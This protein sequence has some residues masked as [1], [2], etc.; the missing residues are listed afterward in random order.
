MQEL[1]FPLHLFRALVR[2][3]KRK[4]RSGLAPRRLVVF[5]GRCVSEIFLREL[6]SLRRRNQKV[7]YT[8][9]TRQKSMT[10]QV[11]AQK[12]GLVAAFKYRVAMVMT[13]GLALV[14]MASAEINFTPIEELLTAVIDL[15][16]SFMDLVVAIAPLVVV[17]AIVSFIL[18]FLDRIISMLNF[19]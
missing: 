16:P 18:K 4:P 15:I 6:N 11:T 12:P 3:V 14:G 13:S 2:I 1:P 5:A 17:I 10:E 19:G 7:L 9:R 8:R